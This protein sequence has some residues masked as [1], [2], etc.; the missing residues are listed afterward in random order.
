MK[1][2]S[3]CVKTQNSGG[4]KPPAGGL[5]PSVLW[6]HRAAKSGLR[7][8][9][10]ALDP[11]HNCVNCHCCHCE[12]ASATAAILYRKVR[13]PQSPRLPRNDTWTYTRGLLN[14]GRVQRTLG[15]PRPP[16]GGFTPPVNLQKL[17]YET[18]LIKIGLSL[19]L[20]LVMLAGCANEREATRPTSA[21]PSVSGTAAPKVARSPVQFTDVT[22]AAGIGFKHTN[23]A[24]GITLQPETMGSG[25]AFIDYDG[26]GFQDLFF[27]NSRHWTDEELNQWKQGDWT[28]REAGDFDRSHPPG[29][30][31]VRT[32]PAER[33]RGHVTGALYHNNGDG[34]FSDVTKSSGLAIEMYGMGVAVGDYDND[35]K[36]DLYVTAYG[37][38]Y[39]FRNESRSA[40]P[41]FREVA[42]QLGVKDGGWSSSATWID[43]DKDGNARFVRVPFS[44]MDAAHRYLWQRRPHS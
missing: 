25:V 44:G 4:V 18:G 5:K 10:E 9:A 38:N 6:T 27:V 20:W 22:K 8:N 31:H 19:F 17:M 2:Y 7:L 41:K 43:Y 12:G 32:V 30:P 14:S 26:D 40:Q 29:T 39:L 13:L 33:E 15:A 36:P 23:G 37:H 34:T 35:G 24:F 28:K 21:T 3:W 42:T 16:A 11:F 1:W